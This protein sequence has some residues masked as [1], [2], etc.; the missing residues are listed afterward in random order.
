LKFEFSLFPVSS[1]NDLEQTFKVTE[2]A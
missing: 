1:I 2:T